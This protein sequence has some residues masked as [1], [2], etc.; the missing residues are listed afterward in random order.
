MSRLIQNQYAMTTRPD[1]VCVFG[2]LP[3]AKEAWL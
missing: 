1:G 3:A 2:R